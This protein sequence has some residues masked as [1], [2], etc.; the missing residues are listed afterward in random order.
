MNNYKQYICQKPWV[1]AQ[2]MPS[3]DVYSCCPAW[4]NG[5]V[6]GNLKEQS[7]NDVW[8]SEKSQKFRE[9]IL[10]G[11]YRYCNEKSCP[12]L[13]N[14]ENALG[15]RDGLT[16]FTWTD[17]VDDIKNQKIILDH[18]PLHFELCYDESCNLSCPSCRSGIK[19]ANGNERIIIDNFHEQIMKNIKSTKMIGVDA[20][21]EALS[22]ITFRNFLINLKKEDAPE[23]TGILL[24]TNGLLIKK[25]WNDLSEYSREKIKSL[26]ISV[27]VDATTK[28]VYEIVRR[29]GKFE[30]LIE[31]LEFIRDHIKPNFFAI[32]TVIQKE[33]YR[34][35]SDFV[36][37]AKKYKCNHL[38]YQILEPDTRIGDDK[39]YFYTWKSQAVHEKTHDLHTDFLTYVNE[40]NLNHTDLSINFG[41]LLNLKRGIDI[42]QLETV[43][44][45]YGKYWPDDI[46][47]VWYNDEVHNVKTNHFKKVVKNEKETDYVYLDKIKIY[48]YWNDDR[49]EWI[50][51]NDVFEKIY[52]DKIWAYGT[53]LS[54]TGSC[55]IGAAD[56]INFLKQYK[57]RNVLDLG[58]GD[59]SIY[60]KN[61]FFNNYIAVDVVDIPKYVDINDV[62]FIKSDIIS[63]NY[64]LYD[65]NLIIIKDVF[66]HLSNQTIIEILNVLR[67]INCEIL[68]TNDFNDKENDDCRIGLHRNLNLCEY[69]FNITP[70]NRYKWISKVDGILKETIICN[71]YGNGE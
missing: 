33:N 50:D 21:G 68:I 5:Y 52:N 1:E 47:K 14:K 27:S 55:P 3:G 60:N 40:I 63:F 10:D 23:L 6:L 70:I 51:M 19:Y 9:S 29:P 12:L 38:Q 11:S 16:G 43:E 36:D 20:A 31:N 69:P 71:L 17:T 28:E 48:V 66:Q 41:P 26:G 42:S 56:Y 57:N 18:G 8:N 24:L 34:Q 54:G 44:I 49:K 4:T 37:F 53:I 67:K 64:H 59:L 65:F 15:K 61:I 58:C 32:S 45:E 22:S 46:K 25:Y 30:N 13:Q 2:I 7:L 39:L 62:K 35:L